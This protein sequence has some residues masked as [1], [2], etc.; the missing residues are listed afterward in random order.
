M[1]PFGKK[2][3]SPT[4]GLKQ[5]K[6]RSTKHPTDRFIPSRKSSKMKTA[7]TQPPDAEDLQ[8]NKKKLD[9]PKEDPYFSLM[10]L[11]KNIVLG[12]D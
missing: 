3:D 4:K 5:K 12:Y 7:F 8:K 11:Y 2:Y 6:K 10:C 1:Y 9:S